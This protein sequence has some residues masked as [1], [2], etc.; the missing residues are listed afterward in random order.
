M[1]TP[2]FGKTGKFPDG[3]IHHSDEGEIQFGI[4]A[5]RTKNVVVLD[6][7]TPVVWLGLPPAV[8]KQLGET[9]IKRAT[10]LEP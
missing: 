9:L 4:A 10:E 7:G 8:A 3:K 5:D 2:R 6:F 1:S